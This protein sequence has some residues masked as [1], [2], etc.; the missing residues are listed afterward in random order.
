MG[1][2][3]SVLL[4][5]LHTTA[6]AG[7]GKQITPQSQGEDAMQTHRV[8]ADDICD[9]WILDGKAGIEKLGPNEVKI[10][11]IGP[12]AI[13]DPTVYDGKVVVTFECMVPEERTKLLLL[14]YGHGSDGMPTRDWKRDGAY[15]GYNAGRMEVYTVAFNRGLHISPRHGDQLANVRRI[16]GPD[17]ATYTG[18][19]FR[20]NRTPD[21]AFWNG[22]NTLSLV[23]AGRE[24]T[25]GLGTF[26]TY[27]M[28]FEPPHMFLA[29]DGVVFTELV[30]HRDGPL[31]T[32]A[33]AFRCMSKG[34]TF[35]IR[36][37]VI[38]GTPVPEK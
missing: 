9:R 23:G 8:T 29:V 11:A 35:V 5:A 20:K 17:L 32:G 25:S 16:G 38:E 31:K 3:T 22:W 28:T 27:T 18:E 2:A 10:S 1:I 13:W 34:K 7:S 4:C 33:F 37:V 36:N 14:A 21:N 15:D 6:A 30:D 24:P 19:N 12:M 26:H